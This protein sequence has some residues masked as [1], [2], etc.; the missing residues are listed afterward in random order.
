MTENTRHSAGAFDIRNVIASLLG[1][2]GIV[3]LLCAAF[4][5]PGVNPDTGLE[6][7]SSDNLWTGVVLIIAALVFI[8][9]AKLNPVVVDEEEIGDAA[10]DVAAAD[11]DGSGV[12]R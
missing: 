12:A 6:K 10:D 8:A 4:L 3:L 9:W 1:I 5:D 2:Y 7:S 11:T